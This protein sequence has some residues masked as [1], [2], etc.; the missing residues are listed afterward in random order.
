MNL[1]PAAAAP[2]ASFADDRRRALA[3]SAPAEPAAAPAGAFRL[4]VSLRGVRLGWVGANGDDWATLATALRRALVLEQVPHGGLTYYR[5]KGS[6]RWLSASDSAYLGFGDWAG[7]CGFSLQD[8]HLVSESNGQ[9]LSLTDELDSSHLFAWNRYAVVDVQLEPLPRPALPQQPLG[10]GIEHVVVLMLSG[11]SFDNLLGGLH[12]KLTDDG[13]YRGLS[14]KERIPVDPSIPDGVCVSVF[15]GTDDAKNGIR[16]YPEPGKLF[17][18]VN[19]QLFGTATPAA[20]AVPTMNGFAWNY[21]QQPAAPLVPGGPLVEPDPRNVMHYHGRTSVPVTWQLATRYAVCDCWHAGGPVQALANRVIAHCGT[22]GLVPGTRRSRVDNADFRTG[23][24]RDLP[25]SPPVK[26]KTVFELLDEAH[27]GQVNWRVYYHDAPASALCAYV[28]DRWKWLGADGGNVVGFRPRLS[29]ETRFEADIRHHRLAK[30]SV[31]EPRYTDF[32]RNG[33]VNASRPGGAGIPFADAGGG[34]LPPPVSVRDGEH[35]LAQVYGILRQHPETF[36]KT[37]LV[38][39]FDE[40]GGLY[41]HVPPPSAVSPFETAPDNFAYDRL[42]VRVPALF[43]NPAIEPGSVYPP[44]EAHGPTPAFDHASL[45]ATVCAQ[46]GVMEPPLTP[47]VKAAPTLA[48]LIPPRPV[49]RL[50]E[51]PPPDVPPSAPEVPGPL[52][53][54]D[55]ARAAAATAWQGPAP[56]G[57]AQALL[58]LLQISQ[59]QRLASSPR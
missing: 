53:S 23:E 51:P 38:V 47:R 50:R 18:D 55:M 10:P 52:L 59:L 15:Q 6:A 30:Y 11:R 31:I 48:G 7:A 25:F 54:P 8:G 26:E 9:A 40:H 32:F 17:G 16:P 14:G 1:D 5:I 28:Y 4:A 35:L 56:H 3:R 29:D 21:G 37:L 2:Q 43:V 19:E 45:I 58:P 24:R 41:D 34:T 27:P 44:R 36:R 33:P 12:A 49:D 57:L 22:P 13:L 46:F 20:G 42:G 39:L